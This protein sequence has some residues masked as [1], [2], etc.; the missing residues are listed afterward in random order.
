MLGWFARRTSLAPRSAQTARQG[1]ASSRGGAADDAP[2][3]V[4]GHVTYIEHLTDTESD[5]EEDGAALSHAPDRATSSAGPP[6]GA[7]AAG[8]SVGR[9]S[10]PGEDAGRDR[11]GVEWKP[12]GAAAE[13]GGP[14]GEDAERW[15]ASDSDCGRSRGRVCVGGAPSVREGGAGARSAGSRFGGSGS[16]PVVR[17]DD[18]GG[19]GCGRG[20]GV[21]VGGGGEGEG[22]DDDV[23]SPAR[24][25]VCVAGGDVG[26]T[27]DLRGG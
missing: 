17:A 23:I 9:G 25:A 4:T 10:S 19:G 22:N 11:S 16:G 7:C 20:D 27:G 3:H 6:A 24:R 5:A 14:R 26:A 15:A 18:H 1:P 21:E 2:G 8:A 12:K 13:R